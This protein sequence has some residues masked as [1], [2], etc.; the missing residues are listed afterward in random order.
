MHFK[1]NYD[2]VKSELV[3]ELSEKAPQYEYFADAGENS[4]ST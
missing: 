2:L 4:N 3:Q 1:E